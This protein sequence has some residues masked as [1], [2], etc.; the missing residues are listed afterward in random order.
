ML[1]MTTKSVAIVRTVLVAALGGLWSL[2]AAAQDYL[3]TGG[4]EVTFGGNAPATLAT[5]FS[6]S[7]VRPGHEETGFLPFVALIFSAAAGAY[8]TL[9]GA[10]TEGWRHVLGA[11]EQAGGGTRPGSGSVALRSSR[12]PYWQEAAAAG[13]RTMPT[14]SRGPAWATTMARS[15]ATATSPTLTPTAAALTAAAKCRSGS[16]RRDAAERRVGGSGRN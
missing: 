11:T 14:S 5:H 7:Q 1:H 3:P 15:S 8:T 13:A 10:P 4:F 16:P 6:A 9:L 12:P 2:G